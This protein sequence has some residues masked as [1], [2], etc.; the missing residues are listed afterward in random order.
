LGGIDFE[1]S[2]WNTDRDEFRNACVGS[3]ILAAVYSASGIH[4]RRLSLSRYFV[5]VIY[6]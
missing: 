4:T 1:A 2:G 5:I 6:M 3:G